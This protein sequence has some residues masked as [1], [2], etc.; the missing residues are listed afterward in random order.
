MSTKVELTEQLK[1]LNELKEKGI[2]TIE[3]YE[4]RSKG[5]LDKIVRNNVSTIENN[6]NSSLPQD[7]RSQIETMPHRHL[8]FENENRRPMT[9]LGASIVLTILSGLLTIRDIIIIIYNGFDSSIL[10]LSIICCIIA[11]SSLFFGIAAIVNG[12]KV[13]KTFNVG[14]NENAE[15]YSRK[16]IIYTLLSILF[17]IFSYL[18]RIL[19][20]FLFSLFR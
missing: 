15:R 20:I 11:A 7:T 14:D 19:L 3:M 4:Q 1:T 18:L 2:I 6:T 17:F 9:W 16:A 5:I 12:S 8:W 13:K 10:I